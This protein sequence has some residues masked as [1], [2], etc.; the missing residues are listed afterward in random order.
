MLYEVITPSPPVAVQVFESPPAC[1]EPRGFYVD[2]IDG[3]RHVDQ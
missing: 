1:I 2:A 3:D